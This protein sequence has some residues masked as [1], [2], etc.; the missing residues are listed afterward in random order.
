M[1]GTI[2]MAVADKPALAVARPGARRKQPPVI[3]ALPKQIL[4]TAV[5]R[6]YRPI[7]PVGVDPLCPRSVPGQVRAA[8]SVAMGC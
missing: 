5:S 1:V 3:R 6:L 2:A 8:T 4:Q 7:E